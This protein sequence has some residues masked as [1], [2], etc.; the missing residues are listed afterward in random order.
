MQ[1]FSQ[2]NTLR[3]AEED[4]FE[5][6]VGKPCISEG[7]FRNFLSK[8]LGDIFGKAWRSHYKRYISVNQ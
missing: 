3:E 4:F 2:K 5:K 8:S 1:G 7:L 6:T